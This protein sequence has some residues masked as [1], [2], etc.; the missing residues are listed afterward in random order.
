VAALPPNPSK[1]RTEGDDLQKSREKIALA[2]AA[3][4]TGVTLYGVPTWQ[5]FLS[6][7]CHLAAIFAVLTIAVLS[8]TRLFGA[9]GIVI[10]RIWVALFLAGM[11]AVYIVRWLAT[12]GGGTSHAW[13]AVEVAA[14]PIYGGLAAF[15]LRRRS[16]LIPIGIAAH[17]LAWDWW[18]WRP[19]SPYIPAWY[20]IGCLL[21]DVS[22]AIYLAVRLPAWRQGHRPYSSDPVSARGLSSPS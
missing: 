3:V 10:E 22:L 7:V 6:D 4:F 14:L 12:D 13:L 5:H 19:P 2:G 11:P 9:R 8:I 21:V 16:W 17:G 15:G 20:A 18:H 1:A